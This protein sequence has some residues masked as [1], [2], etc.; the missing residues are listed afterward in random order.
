[1]STALSWLR[2]DA[3]YAPIA[4]AGLLS[5]LADAG[6][7]ATC[8]WVADGP[9]TVLE[10]DGGP[11]FE[12]MG[13]AIAGAPWP[14]LETIPWAG[15]LRQALKPMLAASEDPVG[16]LRRLRTA[17]SERPAE[18]RLLGAFVTDGALD[19]GGVPG[20]NRL[21]RGVKGDLSGVADKV[22]I[23][24]AELAGELEAG[25]RWRN[26]KSGRGLGLVPEVQTFGG[27]TGPEPS[28]VGS[29]SVLLYR[30]L[31]L[32]ILALPPVPVVRGRNRLVGGPLVTD[33]DR[34]SW[35]RWTVPVDLGSLRLL[36]CL[37]ELHADSPDRRFL[38]G[39]GVSTVY[40]AGLTQISQ[41]LYVFRW[42]ERVM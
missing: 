25:P 16:E 5:A 23:D 38:E 7:R 14:D 26:G 19:A 39:R 4:T 35:P 29:H 3:P 6:Y 8:R 42:G 34:L 28:A 36:F 13:E 30:L 15:K 18:H 40:R 33:G 41:S 32:G 1:M 31:W 2:P 21:L 9:R 24:A 22:T 12:G 17:V 27:T 20:R 37:A 10:I 11:G